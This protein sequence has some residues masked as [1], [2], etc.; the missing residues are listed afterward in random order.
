MNTKMSKL[1]LAIGALV[2]AGGAWAADSA[3]ATATAVVV[4][5][6]AIVKSADMVFGNIVP[7]NGVVTLSTL[8]ARTKTGTTALSTSGAASAAAQFTVTGTGANTFAISYTGSSATLVNGA[9]TMAIDWI[10]EVAAAATGKTDE[11]TDATA[12]TLSSGSAV[13]WAGAKLT[14]GA[15][16]AIGSYTGDLVVTVAYN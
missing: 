7:G 8:A 14:V 11:A 15:T 9:E 13:I 3:T 16:Q 5:P 10:T 1:A 12:G 2:M 6:I 4:T